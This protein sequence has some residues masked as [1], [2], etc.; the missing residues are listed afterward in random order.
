MNAKQIKQALLEKLYAPYKAC[1]LCPLG[2]LGRTSVVFGQG[3]AD[4]KIMFIGEA[5]GQ[6]EDEQGRPFV[7]RSGQLLTKVLA[8]LGL[9]RDDVYITNTV[10]C[11]PPNNRA[12]VFKE[13][14]TCIKILLQEQIKIIQPKVICTLGTSPMKAL[15]KDSLAIT[16]TRGTL[17]S[18]GNI[19]LIP[20]YHPAYILRKPKELPK[21]VADIK[22]ALELAA[23][24]P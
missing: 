14:A 17:Q 18:Y 5:P 2:S 20:T 13:V 21:M 11:R 15:L 12:P 23:T 10:K 16:Q 8:D 19:L 9:N 3:N 22:M 6:K 7:G 1:T 24:I 4:A